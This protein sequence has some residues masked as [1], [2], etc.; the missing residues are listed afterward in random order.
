M[1]GFKSL[2]GVNTSLTTFPPPPWMS[3]LR[4][5]FLTI[6]FLNQNFS[7]V[8][9]LNMSVLIGFLKFVLIQFNTG[10]NIE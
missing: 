8:K 4:K 3:M 1:R 7:N 6:Q 5:L 9:K 2:M 10:V